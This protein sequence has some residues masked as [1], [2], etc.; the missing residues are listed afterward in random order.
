M[1]RW[2]FGNPENY[3]VVKRG[4]GRWGIEKRQNYWNWLLAFF[5][6]CLIWRYAHIIGAI[7]AVVV[8][9]T[10]SNKLYDVVARLMNRDRDR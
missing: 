2:L 1:L 4:K 8:L 10:I 6:F 9:V 5:V 7:I 3:E